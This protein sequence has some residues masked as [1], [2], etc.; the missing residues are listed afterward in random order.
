VPVSFDLFIQIEYNYVA[1]NQCE[2]D[3]T[4]DLQR[5]AVARLHRPGGRGKHG[6]ERTAMG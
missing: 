5:R 3:L 2:L 1:I 4:G 6:M